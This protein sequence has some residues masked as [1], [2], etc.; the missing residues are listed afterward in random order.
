MCTSCKHLNA[1]LQHL[2]C[3][4][5]SRKSLSVFYIKPVHRPQCRFSFLNSITSNISLG[6][7]DRLR[8]LT[9]S[10]LRLPTIKRRSWDNGLERSVTI[11]DFPSAHVTIMPSRSNDSLDQNPNNTAP[12]GAVVVAPKTLR[13][14]YENIVNLD[15]L[16]Q[17]FYSGARRE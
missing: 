8:K 1:R 17:C 6:P 10:F 14:F 2:H 3:I 7:G 16:N 4:C 5:I 9:S 15:V 13:R 12:D 11:T